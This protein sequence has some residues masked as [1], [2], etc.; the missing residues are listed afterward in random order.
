MDQIKI[1][2]PHTW[3][4]TLKTRSLAANHEKKQQQKKPK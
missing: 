1:V 3:V 2:L 4:I